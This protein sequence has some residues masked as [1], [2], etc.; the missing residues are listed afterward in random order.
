MKKVILLGDSIRQIGYGTRV[1]QLLEGEF[2]VW[3]PKDNCKFAEFTLRML[4]D[5]RKELA[6]ADAIHWNNGHWDLCELFGDGPFT[7][8]EVY[9]ETM[10]R[11]AKLLKRYTDRLIFATTT[12]VWPEY[13]YNRD[14]LICQFN[15]L[16]VP[17]LRAMGFEI[18]DLYA[19]VKPRLREYIRADDML[20]L[21]DAG[22][23]ACA[24]QTAD[25]IRGL[26]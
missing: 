1:P 10:L 16:V 8:P 6:N 2:E 23:E 9:L 7:P 25:K 26:F 18:N 24:R 12:P 20:H 14:E 11:I 22:I 3:Q 21:T 4:F 17:E 13:T 15:S 19:L 5:Y